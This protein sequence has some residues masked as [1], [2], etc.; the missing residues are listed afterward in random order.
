MIDLFFQIL[1][2]GI[3]VGLMVFGVIR[4]FIPLLKKGVENEKMIER[5]LHDDH[6]SLLVNQKHVDESIMVQESDCVD[7]FNKVNLWKNTVQKEVQNKEAEKRF[8][9]EEA[10]KR[11]MI[12]A[13]YHGI[14]ARYAL[15]SSSVVKNLEKDM[16]AHFSDEHVAHEYI[17]RLL[18]GLKK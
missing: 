16:V 7:F 9:L 17:E 1:N 10:E 14:K 5:N 6:R 18:K 13:H 15:L 2:F 3:I 11:M 8:L 12:Q 4:F